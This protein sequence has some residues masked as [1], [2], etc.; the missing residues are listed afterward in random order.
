MLFRR[1][2]A[3]KNAPSISWAVHENH[4][5]FWVSKKPS[6]NS[7][8]AEKYFIEHA[9]YHLSR[10]VGGVSAV[11]SLWTI[12]RCSPSCHS[13]YRSVFRPAVGGERPRISR[14][15]RYLSCQKYS[16]DIITVRATAVWRSYKEFLC[17][18]FHDIIIH[19]INRTK[20]TFQFFSKNLSTI[21]RTLSPEMCLS[22]FLA[23][24]GQVFPLMYF[25]LI[26]RLILL[27]CTESR[28]F[29]ISALCRSS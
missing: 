2:E 23:I 10:Y 16:A 26:M 27:S 17:S 28:K 19:R 8:R 21:F 20:R 1:L 11:L 14:L 22:I 3:V 18:L 4:F 24:W 29:S 25:S 5:L 6:A 9:S 13:C 7:K 15:L 12:R